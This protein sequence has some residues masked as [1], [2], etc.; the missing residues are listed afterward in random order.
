MPSGACVFGSTLLLLALS[1]AGYA[2]VTLSGDGIS[3][4]VLQELAAKNGAQLVRCKVSSSSGVTDAGLCSLASAARELQELELQGLEKP[5]AGAGA[6][7][8]DR[9]TVN[10]K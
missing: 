9:C 8:A 1:T 2:E 3:D 10:T 5:C 7:K 6:R 4:R